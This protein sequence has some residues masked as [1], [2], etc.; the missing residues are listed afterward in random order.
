M[1]KTITISQVVAA[2]TS[3]YSISNSTTSAITAA[4][5]TGTVSGVASLT[6]AAAGTSKTLPADFVGA[7]NKRDGLLVGGSAMVVMGVMMLL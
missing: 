3:T 7:A 5:G 2:V 1:T 6:S 4:V